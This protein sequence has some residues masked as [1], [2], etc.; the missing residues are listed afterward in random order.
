M[1]VGGSC[2]TVEAFTVYR[3]LASLLLLLA[4]P[5]ATK[6]EG[7]PVPSLLPLV[8][9]SQAVWEKNELRLLEKEAEAIK[10]ELGRGNLTDRERRAW[11]V[12]LDRVLAET[13]AFKARLRTTR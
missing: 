8:A 1:M 4:L 7:L 6:A 10:A 2:A 13:E 11:M 9:A 3:V 12:R 5:A